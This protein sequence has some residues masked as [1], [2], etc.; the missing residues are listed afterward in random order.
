MSVHE[1]MCI[2]TK[3]VRPNFSQV[4]AWYIAHNLLHKFLIMLSS[5]PPC[6]FCLPNFNFL[7]TTNST[8][9]DFTFLNFPANSPVEAYPG[10]ETALENLP[11]GDEEVRVTNNDSGSPRVSTKGGNQNSEKSQTIS[12]HFTDKVNFPFYL[13]LYWNLSKHDSC[14]I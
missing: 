8:V 10:K 11:C 7:C 12:N 2:R 9:V 5:T 1:S 13:P 4:F 3:M 14:L 6:L